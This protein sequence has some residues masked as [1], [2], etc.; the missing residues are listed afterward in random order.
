MQKITPRTAQ[1]VTLIALTGVCRSQKLRCLS[2]LL[3]KGV[4]VVFITEYAD[5]TPTGKLMEAIIESVDE[6]YSNN[7]AHEVTRAMGEAASQGFHPSYPVATRN[8]RYLW[9]VDL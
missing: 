8:F 6:F 3:R 2:M 1:A 4:R 5:D 7:W 9:R